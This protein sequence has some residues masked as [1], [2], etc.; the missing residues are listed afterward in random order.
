MLPT[1]FL[2]ERFE[3]VVVSLLASVS[4]ALGV[5]IFLI[6]KNLQP[7][8][9]AYRQRRSGRD[10]RNPDAKDGVIEITSL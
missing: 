8:R 9:N 3:G 6:S 4:L 1:Q 10:C 2:L 5:I 7:T